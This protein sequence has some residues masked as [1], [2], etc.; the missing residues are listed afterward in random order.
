MYHV[1][2]PVP[3]ISQKPDQ[4][5]TTFHLNA[6]DWILRNPKISPIQQEQVIVGFQLDPIAKLNDGLVGN[7]QFLLNLVI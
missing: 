2:S 7:S 6:T 5:L 4:N 1:T 3:I